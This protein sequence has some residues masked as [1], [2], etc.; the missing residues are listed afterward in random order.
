[1]NDGDEQE[2]K[3]P[4]LE[5]IEETREAIEEL[6]KSLRGFLEKLDA[7]LQVSD[8]VRAGTYRYILDENHRAVPEPD[9][10]RWAD[11]IEDEKNRIVRSEVVGMYHVSTIFVGVDHCFM[12]LL[13]PEK[14]HAPILYETMVFGAVGN[15]ERLSIQERCSTWDEAIEQHIRIVKDVQKMIAG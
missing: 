7:G 5:E 4:S 8:M 9:T 10:L 15:V 14:P 3:E 2:D 13:H 11:W 12:G 6:A 1:M